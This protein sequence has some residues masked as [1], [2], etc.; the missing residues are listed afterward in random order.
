MNKHI[1]KPDWL[2]IRLGNNEK[3]SDTSHLLNN[4][5]MNTICVSG[6]CPNQGECWSKGTAT[7]MIC[8]DICTR[9]C[10]FCNTKT[11]RPLNPDSSEPQRLADTIRDLGIRYAVITSVDR[12]DLEDFGA[13]HWEEC[14]KNIKHVNPDIK[15][16][17]LIPDFNGVTSLLDMII[18]QSPHVVAHN[19][20]TVRRLTP[21]V[22]SVAKYDKS[23]N[24]IR[25]IAESGITAKS[26][27]DRK[28]VV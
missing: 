13:N 2:K 6:R 12:D 26:G 22:R 10:R 14:L 25:H 17:A 27:L 19:I 4:N 3:Y 16:E 23:L 9:S 18:G 28:R 1:P 15:I 8:G 20:E 21:E 11:G 24:V 7:F 5:C